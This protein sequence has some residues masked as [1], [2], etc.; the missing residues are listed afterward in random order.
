MFHKNWYFTGQ[1]G[2]TAFYGDVS[3][4]KNRFFE[5]SPFSKFYYDDRGL[6]ISFQ[7]GK[8]L[9]PY[10]STGLHFS[11]GN[12][13]GTSEILGLYMNSSIY[14][15][16]LNG[17]VNVL[18]LI[19][20]PSSYRPLNLY[21]TFGV[22][23]LSFRTSTRDLITDTLVGVNNPDIPGDYSGTF[24]SATTV[25]LNYGFGIRYRIDESVSICFESSTQ[26]L[27]NDNLDAHLSDKRGFEGYNRMSLGLTYHF[28]MSPHAF[29]TRYPTYNEK[30][31]DPA[32]K[33]FNKRKQVIMDTP[34]SRKASKK[35][36][37]NRKGRSR[38]TFRNMFRKNKLLFA[39]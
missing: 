35:R 5:D 15:Y 18:N 28:D 12:L 25:V 8:D 24:F 29:R 26:A 34:S 31:N 21:G 1:V 38:I 14:E 36:Y 16:G 4:K 3:D 11:A 20:G 32:I 2:A 7:Y 9:N 39:K 27:L 6:A 17:Q 13:L 19:L 37:D 10:F 22:S 33:K 23:G 30:S